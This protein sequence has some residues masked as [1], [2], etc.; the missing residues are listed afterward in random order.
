MNMYMIEQKIAHCFLLDIKCS[1]EISNL[2]LAN[3]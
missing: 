3:T 2:I 1:D